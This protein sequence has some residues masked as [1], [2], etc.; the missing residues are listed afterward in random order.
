VFLQTVSAWKQRSGICIASVMKD[1][2]SKSWGLMDKLAIM[3][4]FG[5]FGAK[6]RALSASANLT[7]RNGRAKLGKLNPA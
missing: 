4:Q 2:L 7:I 3:Q 1:G 6:V 5:L